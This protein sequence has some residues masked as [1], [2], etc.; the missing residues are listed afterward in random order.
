[1][2]S[3]GDNHLG[4]KITV[5]TRNSR[6]SGHVV[7]IGQASRAILMSL[8]DSVLLKTFLGATLM[9]GGQETGGSE[10]MPCRDGVPCLRGT[11]TPH[12]P[13][14]LGHCLVGPWGAG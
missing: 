7:L 13:A 14:E 4:I 6:I 1:M 5:D 11:R 3:N 9:L 2:N 8:Q 10:R 12:S